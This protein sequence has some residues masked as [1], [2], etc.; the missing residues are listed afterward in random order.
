M[1]ASSNAEAIRRW[2]DEVLSR[3]TTELWVVVPDDLVTTL[4]TVDARF[5]DLH[6]MRMAYGCR[7]TYRYRPSSRSGVT[8][9]DFDPAIE[10]MVADEDTCRAIAGICSHNRVHGLLRKT[11]EKEGE[12]F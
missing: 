4:Y 1:R 7:Y 9:F 12:R 5:E 3:P 2:R 10:R 8:R 11:R 6:L